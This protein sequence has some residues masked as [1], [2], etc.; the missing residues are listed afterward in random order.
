M[1][2]I[3]YRD[4]VLA[5]DSLAQSLYSTRSGTIQKIFD[6]EHG[7][8]ASTTGY[9]PAAQKLLHWY[10]SEGGHA[11]LTEQPGA[12]DEEHIGCIQVFWPDGI[13]IFEKGVRQIE[14]TAPFHAYGAG[15]EIALGAM[16]MGA[17][18]E[19]A[20]EAAIALHTSCGGPVQ[21]LRRAGG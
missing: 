2:V 11:G 6:L 5:S 9:A 21:V 17:T 7:V 12:P 13:E 18:A 20:V 1:T 15:R 19:Q 14:A 3:C 4:G 8:F 16:W 10:R